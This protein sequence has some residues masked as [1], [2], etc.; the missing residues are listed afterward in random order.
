MQP[1]KTAVLL[2]PRPE[3]RETPLGPEAKKDG[4]LERE[5]N[6]IPTDP[7]L[8]QFFLSCF[9]ALTPICARPECGKETKYGNACYTGKKHRLIRILFQTEIF[10]AL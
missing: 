7:L 10:K 9:F 1:A 4:K 2:R 8:R 3:W 5:Q 6:N